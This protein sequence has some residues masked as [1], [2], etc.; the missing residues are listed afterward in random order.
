MSYY[1][2]LQVLS[3]DVV[4]VLKS[5]YAINT[6]FPF[7]PFQRSVTWEGREGAGAKIICM[8]GRGSGEGVLGANKLP[9]E[10]T[11]PPPS[12]VVLST[13]CN[14]LAEKQK[15]N[16]CNFQLSIFRLPPKTEKI[17]HATD[18]NIVR[19]EKKKPLSFLFL[20]IVDR[21]KVK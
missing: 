1:K 12:W 3:N 19:E 14:I 6:N 8:E 13:I 5:D 15:L 4:H 11:P 18:C 7:P 17:S 21:I 2:I 10:W 16:D 9:C 20:F